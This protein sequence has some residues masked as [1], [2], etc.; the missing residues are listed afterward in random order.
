MPVKRRTSKRRFGELAHDEWLSLTLGD[1]PGR[2][3]F[4]N[5]DERRAAWEHHGAEL[6]ANINPGHRPAAWW[7]YDSPEPREEGVKECTQLWRMGVMTERELAYHMAFWAE[8]AAKARTLHFLIGPFN[9]V[10]A[11]EWSERHWRDWAGI[12]DE[13]FRE[14]Q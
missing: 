3:G 5:E 11:G 10:D 7:D 6:T 13:L 14:A 1:I 4:D 2:P 9:I 12:P 8:W